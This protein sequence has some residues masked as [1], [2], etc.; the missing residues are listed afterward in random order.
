MMSVT[1]GQVDGITEEIIGAAIEVHRQLGP[2]LLES[3]YHNC[4]C[5]ELT[6]R[7]IP[8]DKE[9]TLPILYKG[10]EVDT[11]YRLDILVRGIVVVELKA[12]EKTLPIHHA[13][14]LTYLRIWNYPAGLLLN[15]NVSKLTKGVNRFVNN[16]RE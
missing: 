12:V 8:H 11:G 13:Q 6:L 5:H 1:R 14:I 15:F 2:G 7:R 10:I 9:L 16:L 3:A 4:L